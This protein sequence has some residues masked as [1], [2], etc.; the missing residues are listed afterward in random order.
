MVQE[1]LRHP[2]P[3]LELRVSRPGRFPSGTEE[4]V[5]ETQSFSHVGPVMDSAHALKN[6]SWEARPICSRVLRTL[7]FIKLVDSNCWCLG[8]RVGK[9][10]RAA[11]RSCNFQ[12]CLDTNTAQ[13]SMSW[14]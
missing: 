6:S 12:A 9:E 11:K 13:A 1:L 5:R 3:S 2:C 10:R 7:A 14:P 8:Y 4:D